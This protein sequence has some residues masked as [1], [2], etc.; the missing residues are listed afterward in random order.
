ML[1]KRSAT[2]EIVNTV[3]QSDVD[4]ARGNTAAGVQAAGVC[5]RHVLPPARGARRDE[6]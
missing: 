2:D 1:G 4:L 3:R 6:G 5:G